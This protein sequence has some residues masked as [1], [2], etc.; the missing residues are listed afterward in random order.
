MASATIQLPGVSG[1]VNQ[2]DAVHLLATDQCIKQ[3]NVI[4]SAEGGAAKRLGCELIAN[5]SGSG[6]ALSTGVLYLASGAPHIVVHTSIG[7]IVYS[8]DF[9]ATWEVIDDGMSTT[10]PFSYEEY[11]GKLYMSNGVDDYRSW[12]GTTQTTYP[13]APK[14]KY[15]RLWKDSMWVSGVAVYPDRAYKSIA[16]DPETYGAADW[17]DILHG[18]GDVVTALS[19]DGNYLIVFKL[20]SVT[21][22][23]DPV[24]FANQVVDPEKGCESHFS[25][26]MFNGSVFFLSRRGICVFYSDQPSVILSDNV[27]PTFRPE[28]LN[29]D[30]LTTSW[31]YACEDR[32]G[33]CL[34]ES[35][36][37]VPTVQLEFYPMI[38]RKPWNFHRMPV[39]MLIPVRY[40]EDYFL[41]GPS[42]GSYKWYKA[43]SVDTGT[44]DSLPFNAVVQTG[45]F[46]LGDA[47]KTKYIRRI[48]L[49]GRGKFY[50]MIKVDFKTS[51][52]W[53]SL[54]DLGEPLEFWDKTKKWDKTKFWGPGQSDSESAF[55]PDVYGRYISLV[56]QDSYTD[57]TTDRIYMGS[58]KVT[59]HAGGWAIHSIAIEPTLLG[60]RS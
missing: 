31:G 45:W 2:R 20:K 11:N 23:I 43:F 50:I 49:L 37:D 51:T 42:V 46:N 14:G 48:Q 60:V 10:A 26:V 53:S 30:K 27:S 3:E 56:Y 12:N 32:V 7:E 35:G 54:V 5:F 9:G 41:Y 33:W 52:A 36:S 44:D 17:V 18:N 8:D 4:L 15:L 6:Y 13:T 47:G 1:G 28:V 58:E 57:T 25:C 39:T 16:A 19:A 29:F 22:V 21:S 24:T 40:Q 38:A 34:P 55:F 59:I